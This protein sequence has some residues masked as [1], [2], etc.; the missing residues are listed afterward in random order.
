MRGLAME[1]PGVSKSWKRSIQLHMLL[2]GCQP[3]NRGGPNPPKMDGE[4][5]GGSNPMIQWMDLGGF[6][7]YFWKH[8]NLKPPWMFHSEGVAHLVPPVSGKEMLKNRWCPA[9]PKRAPALVATIADQGSTKNKTHLT[10]NSIFC[11]TTL[12]SRVGISEIWPKTRSQGQK[13]K[14]MQLHFPT[15]VWVQTDTVGSR[16]PDMAQLGYKEAPVRSCLRHAHVVRDFPWF[17]A[18]IWGT[19]KAEV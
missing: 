13:K 5:N 2:N 4:N 9:R 19:N 17:F 16:G 8:L 3:K 1:W 14:Q 18:A 15:K 7:P 11:S 10:F 12:K 6:Y